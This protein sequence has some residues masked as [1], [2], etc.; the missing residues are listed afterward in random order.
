MY[1]QLNKHVME[2]IAHVLRCTCTLCVEHRDKFD[3]G[4][5]CILHT[6]SEYVPINL[7]CDVMY[8]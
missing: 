5:N 2:L 6:D 7:Y 4:Q 8:M 3:V 1:K